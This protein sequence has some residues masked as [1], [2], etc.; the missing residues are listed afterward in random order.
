MKFECR[1]EYLYKAI[2][3]VSKARSKSAQQ[4]PLQDIFFSLSDHQLTIRSTNLEIMCE[5]SIPVKGYVNGE[6]RVFGEVISKLAVTSQK[7]DTVLLCERVDSLLTIVDK[8]IRIE[9]KLQADEPFP[10][11]P[12]SGED[13][14]TLESVKLTKLLRDVSFCSATTDIKPEIA[15]VYLYSSQSNEMVAVATDSFRLA[16]RKI[17]IETNG[18]F[19]LMIPAKNINDITSILDGEGGFCTISINEQTVTFTTESCVITSHTIF[20]TYPDY[21]QLF[22]KEFTT[23][24]TV[25]KQELQKALSVNSLFIESFSSTHFLFSKEKLL[26]KSKSEHTGRIDQ[27]IQSK[28]EGVEIDTHYNNRLLNEVFPHLQGN[29]IAL[30]LTTAQRP[31]FMST[32]DDVSYTYLIMPITR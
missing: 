4:L 20:G 19:S 24:V 21:R 8:D 16:E 12:L 29:E 15:S 5:K 28:H 32:T 10:T 2:Q 6:C 17:H 30:K 25:N 26:L 31:L 22:P 11:L 7:D 23:T 13:V 27:S 14:V 9:L 1:K 3:Q 18:T